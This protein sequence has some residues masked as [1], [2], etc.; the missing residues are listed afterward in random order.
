MSVVGCLLTW[1]ACRKLSGCVHSLQLSSVAFTWT[2]CVTLSAF[3]SLVISHVYYECGGVFVCVLYILAQILWR[4]L[5]MSVSICPKV[6]S[7]C[8]CMLE[9]VPVLQTVV[10]FLLFCCHRNTSSSTAAVP[11]PHFLF[12]FPSVTQNWAALLLTHHLFPLQAASSC[13]AAGF[14]SKWKS[15]IYIFECQEQGYSIW[16]HSCLD[17][18]V[19]FKTSVLFTDQ[20]TKL[21]SV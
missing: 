18:S 15:S 16:S 2:F 3:S 5:S 1:Q 10:V 17:P 21:T 11:L 9:L 4:I 7:V 13:A 19:H 20:C 12:S 8:D 6:L 14:R